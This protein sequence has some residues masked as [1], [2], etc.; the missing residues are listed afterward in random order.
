MI[1]LEPLAKTKASLTRLQNAMQNDIKKFRAGES[2]RT[3]VNNLQTA[4]RVGISD[5]SVAVENDEAIGLTMIRN[6]KARYTG[7]IRLLYS[8]PGKETAVTPMLVQHAI[9]KVWAEPSNQFLNAT[10]F[11]DQAGVRDAFIAD[12]ALRAE[13]EEMHLDSLSAFQADGQLPDGFRFAAWSPEAID[14][15]ARM[16]VDAYEGTLDAQIYPDMQTLPAMQSYFQEALND[17]G[18]SFDAQASTLIY[19]GDKLAALLVSTLASDKRGYIIEMNV[20]QAYRRRGLARALMH[21]ALFAFTAEGLTGAKLWATVANPAYGFYQ[22]LGF[23]THMP[24]WVYSA[25]R[26]AT[27][28]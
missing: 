5:A 20:A 18:H 15:A 9:A 22:S 8:V 6:D 13:R 3:L 24:M 7:D 4:A 10:L 27:T 14:S 19:E 2:A 21:H 25:Q 17:A 11:I 23:H 26:P 12:G 1:T 28:K 16:S